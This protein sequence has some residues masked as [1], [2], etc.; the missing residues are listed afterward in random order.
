MEQPG[1]SLGSTPHR[2]ARLNTMVTE[3]RRSK[4]SSRKKAQKRTPKKQAAELAI[5]Q[6]RVKVTQFRLAA[7]SIR[8]IAAHLK[9]SVG[10]VHSDLAEVECRT[11]DESDSAMKVERMISLQR[12]D[13]A[14][15]GL[16]PAI[17][18][19][20]PDA[21]DRLVKL[22]QRRAKLLGLDKPD[23]KEISGPDGEPLV[24]DARQA[25]LERISR[26]VVGEATSEPAG[27][28]DPESDAGGGG[29]S[30]V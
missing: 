11:R 19:G 13:V 23:R 10:T 27:G 12:L 4:K 21:I 15:K 6:R 25:L 28:S 1:S 18:S 7:W 17:E 5:E 26:L 22:D 29:G 2:L 30:P 16:W 20:D 9:C 8:D 14:T 3:R 24:I